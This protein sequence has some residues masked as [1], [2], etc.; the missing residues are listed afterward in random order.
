MPYYAMR[1]EEYNWVAIRKFFKKVKSRKQTCKHFGMSTYMFDKA[2]RLGEIKLP[3]D[4][5]CTK[6][7]HDNHPSKGVGCNIQKML[8]SPESEGMTYAQIGAKFGCSTINVIY[9]AHA[10][11]LPNRKNKP[12][13]HYERD[14]AEVQRYLDKVQNLKKVSEKFG[15][16][17]NVIKKRF[18]RGV[19]TR[20]AG[21]GDPANRPGRGPDKRPRARRRS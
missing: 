1:F 21:I 9:H 5:H 10:L 8:L 17:I 14:W 2:V 15:I 3:K 12:P 19:L 18:E 13:E 7:L 6:Y 16:S 20:P 4:W 11:G